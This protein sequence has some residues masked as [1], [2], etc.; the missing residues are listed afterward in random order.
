MIRFSRTLLP[1]LAVA[2]LLVPVAQATA[3][4]PGAVPTPLEPGPFTVE[5]LCDFPVILEFSGKAGEIDL[6]GGAVIFTGPGQMVTITN[7][8]DPSK[9]VTLSITGTFM[10]RE[11]S[12]V[13]VARGRSVIVLP[14]QGLALIVGR[15][16]FT[17]T[18]EGEVL[19]PGGAG[20]ITPV[21]PMIA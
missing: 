16:L 20:T 14:G 18:E 8:E 13:T 1:L 10:S 4:Q 19:Q 11:G 7:A 21:C 5:G 17:E 15:F 6:P 12:D 9:S 2:A 3:A